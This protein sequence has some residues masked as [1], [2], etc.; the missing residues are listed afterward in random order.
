MKYTAQKEQVNAWL[1]K[2]AEQ[3]SVFAPKAI[4]KSITFQTYTKDE[5]ASAHLTEL[6]DY[7]TVSAKKVYLPETEVLLEYTAKKQEEDLSKKDISV[8]CELN[9]T[10]KIVFGTRPCDAKAVLVQD[11]QYMGG[12]Y[13]DPYYAA[14]RENTFM[15]TQTCD[16]TLPSC[17]CNWTDTDL[18]SAYASDILFTTTDKGYVFEAIT[19]K[20]KEL[21]AL[22]AFSEATDEDNKIVEAKH[23]KAHESLPKKPDMS[24][25]TQIIAYNFEN[26][27]FWAK[28]SAGCI[29]CSS[30]TFV[31]PTCQ[32]FTITDE[33]NPLQGKRMRSWAS[34]MSD[35]FT[36]E[37]SGHN[38]RG[39][40][41]MRWRNRLGHKF[42]YMLSW[43][44]DLYSCTGCGRCL[45]SCPA[46]ISINGMITS[47][48]NSTPNDADLPAKREY[49]QQAEA[50]APIEEKT[51][52]KAT[53]TAKKPAA[54]KTTKKTE[55]EG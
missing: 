50:S 41:F 25:I 10:Q 6:L 18:T 24:Q 20:G 19:E 9:S 4:A 51:T 42:N 16:E 35:E 29:G 21:L 54:K 26:S 31:C 47:I 34:C 23:Q 52:V 17:F 8:N 48:I 49:F 1:S 53:A 37:A 7:T 27:D 3:Y 12:K 43:H 45:G 14:H 44:K 55:N 28:V 46:S 15:I 2:L 33:G 39:V 22:G 11:A 36:R 38:P 30:C 13:R 5:L 40:G 32:C